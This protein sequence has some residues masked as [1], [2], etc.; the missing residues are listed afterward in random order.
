MNTSYDFKDQRCHTHVLQDKTLYGVQRLFKNIQAFSATQSNCFTIVIKYPGGGFKSKLHHDENHLIPIHQIGHI[1]GQGRLITF[2][3]LK[4]LLTNVYKKQDANI[5]M[6]VLYISNPPWHELE[7]WFISWSPPVWNWWKLQ[8]MYSQVTCCVKINGKVSHRFS[9]S[10]GVRQGCVLNTL[11][12]YIWW[13]DISF[14]DT[15]WLIVNWTRGNKFLWIS[16]PDATI[17]KQ[18]NSFEDVS[19]KT[20]NILSLPRCVHWG[21]QDPFIWAVHQYQ[22]LKLIHTLHLTEC[23]YLN[24]SFH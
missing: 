24:F 16:H 1:R 18:G 2:W 9:S 22:S 14:D 10:V 23:K 13:Y 17:F 4:F 20:A 12:I 7:E 21:R 15:W 5:C 6:P 8:S 3:N 19:Y 11:Y